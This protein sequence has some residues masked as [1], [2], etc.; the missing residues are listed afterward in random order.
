MIKTGS[1]IASAK[2]CT[3]GD[4]QDARRNSGIL[5]YDP[6]DIGK[7]RILPMNEVKQS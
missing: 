3:V 7:V 4:A 5:R 1:P 6:G 2:G